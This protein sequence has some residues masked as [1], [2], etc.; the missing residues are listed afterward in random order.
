MVACAQSQLTV[1][2]FRSRTP[3]TAVET[4]K[5]PSLSMLVVSQR[6]HMSARIDL[7]E[8]NWTGTRA[9]G[10]LARYGGLK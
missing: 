6:E 5:K 9:F 4:E 10:P 1:N 8:L 7:P 2:S 3:E